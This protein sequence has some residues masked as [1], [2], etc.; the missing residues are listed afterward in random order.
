[1]VAEGLCASNS[2]Q[3]AYDIC[4]WSDGFINAL[5]SALNYSI[6]GKSIDGRNGNYEEYGIT[7]VYNSTDTSKS[8]ISVPQFGA[9]NPQDGSGTLIIDRI[10]SELSNLESISANAIATLQR[11][12]KEINSKLT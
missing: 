2:V 12:Q 11:I 1:M 10:M 4:D 8:S 3:N 9:I 6:T 7:T 5:L